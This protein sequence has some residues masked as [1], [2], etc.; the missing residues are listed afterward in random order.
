ML[1]LGS[2]WPVKVNEISRLVKSAS[3]NAGLSL[4][5]SIHLGDCCGLG[6][7]FNGD[8]PDPALSLPVGLLPALLEI[9]ILELREKCGLTSGECI[10]RRDTVVE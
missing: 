8:F 10:L 3:I 5:G 4:Q 7:S 2:R 9:N 1:V 6:D